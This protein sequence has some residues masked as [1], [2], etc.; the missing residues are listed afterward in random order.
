M[1]HFDEKGEL[2]D[3]KVAEY[4]QAVLAGRPHFHISLAMDITP[5]C[6]CWLSSDA[7]V[8]PDIGMFAS[9]DPVA[10]DLACVE[11]LQKQPVI[12]NSMLGEA[13]ARGGQDGAGERV[14]YI[15]AIH[16]HSNWRVTVDHAVKLGI[17]SDQYELIEVD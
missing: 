5:L 12:A 8:V 3:A 15:Q 2:L 1:A 11:A 14:D 6:D 17:G 4:A 7:A 13:L 9:F 16:P 10:L